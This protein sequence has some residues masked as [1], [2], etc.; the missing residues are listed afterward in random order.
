MLPFPTLTQTLTFSCQHHKKCAPSTDLML[1]IRNGIHSLIMRLFV[2]SVLLFNT[3]DA[4]KILVYNSKYAHSHSNFLGNIADVLVD[5]GHNVTSLIPI[6][7]KDVHDAKEKSSKIYIQASEETQKVMNLLNSKKDNFFK[8]NTFNPLLTLRMRIEFA[9]QFAF[10]CKAVLDE[11][12]LLERLKNEHYDVVIVENFDMCSV[13]YAHL[14][15]PKSLITTSAA[16]PFSWMYHEFGMPLSLSFNPSS[17]I[18]SMNGSFWNRVKNIYA[19]WLMHLFFYPGRWMVEDV[20]RERYGPSFPSLQEISSHAAY[21]LFNTEPLIDFA[22]PTLNRIVNIGG[23]GA[24]DPAPIGKEW[25]QL[26][27]RCSQN[28]LLSFGSVA[29]SIYLP[30]D[31]KESIVNTIARFPDV[32][33]IWKYENPDD[34][35]AKESTAALPNLHLSKWMP[36]NDLLADKRITAFITHGGMGSTQ[37]TAIRGKPGIFI[38]IFADQPRNA[39]MMEYNGVGKVLGKFDLINPDIFEAAIRDVLTNDSY[40]KNAERVSAMLAKKPFTSREQLIK[41]V[42]FAAEYGPSPALRPQSY[43]MNIIQYHN[44]DIIGAVIAIAAVFIMISMKTITLLLS[45]CAFKFA[46]TTIYYM[47]REYGCQNEENEDE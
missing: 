22:V 2:F 5:A 47:A 25:D 1:P 41:T 28:I 7:D 10:Q 30:V 11:V 14:L 19:E 27:S 40:R 36:Q 38:P 23:I 8:L 9:Q 18:S 16:I 33:F 26:L 34:D 6:I 20:F 43:D 44:L 32:T 13:G 4:Y 15:Q 45:F 17:Y 37:E 42:E 12:Q 35:F 29:K 39:G 3:F 31:V 46:F 21:T 24:K